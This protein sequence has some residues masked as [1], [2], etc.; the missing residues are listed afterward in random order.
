MCSL[1]FV[2][3]FSHQGTYMEM[4]PKR[5]CDCKKESIGVLLQAQNLS[6]VNCLRIF[7]ELFLYEKCI[8]VVKLANSESPLHIFSLGSDE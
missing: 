7:N 2:A 6:F 5:K 4:S 1:E 8:Q 3:L